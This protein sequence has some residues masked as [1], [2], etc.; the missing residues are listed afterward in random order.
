VDPDLRPTIA[1]LV[2]E[3]RSRRAQEEASVRE[4]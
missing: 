1:L 2:E 3:E 4:A